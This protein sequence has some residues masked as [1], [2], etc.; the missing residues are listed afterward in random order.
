MSGAIDWARSRVLVAGGGGF[1]GR[2]VVAALR[3]RGCE[4]V[5]PRT[6]DGWDLRREERAEALIAEARPEIVIDCAADQGGIA[7]VQAR[8]ADVFT[9]NLLLGA[10]LMR[11]AVRGGVHTYVSA[12][13]ACSYPGDVQGLLREE[14]YWSGPLHESVLAY[15]FTKK[16]RLV[17]AQCYARQYGLRAVNLV[18]ANLY[19]PGDHLDPERSHALTAL[20]V[21]IVRAV[22]DGA[23]E[24]VVWGSGDP[25]REWLYVEDAAE[26]LVVGA[27]RIEDAEPYNVGTGVG[28]S[29]R[30][31]A[32]K[33]AALAGFAGTLRYDRSRPD[34]APFKTLA[35]ERF[36]KAAGWRARTSLDDGLA[37]TLEWVRGRI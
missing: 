16:A 12:L 34:G 9:N 21:K 23:S 32:E 24:V 18:L 33:I 36:A 1:L 26:A 22:R 8:P 25:V 27:E 29:I 31:L 7:Y 13:A 19:G 37:R 28:L 14:D 10:N 15:G 5:V 11:A 35:V 2:H 17:Q 6:K 30:E 4:P 3:S 20:L